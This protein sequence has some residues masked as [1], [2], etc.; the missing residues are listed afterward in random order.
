MNDLYSRYSVPATVSE[1]LT[2][3]VRRY[4]SAIEITEIMK[5]L[6]VII[7]WFDDETKLDPKFYLPS[8]ISGIWLLPLAHRCLELIPSDSDEIEQSELMI[9]EAL[10]HATILFMQ[11]IRRRFGVNPGPTDLRVRKLRAI[12]QQSLDRWHGFEALFR[13]I[14]V[15]ARM[16][17]RMIEDQLWFAGVLA[18]YEPF[19]QLEEEEHL[20]ALRAFIWKEDVFEEP[21]A[22]FMDQVNEIKIS[23]PIWP[24][25]KSIFHLCARAREDRAHMLGSYDTPFSFQWERHFSGNP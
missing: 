4:P 9:L 17:A 12:L 20:N 24:P 5:D 18:M 7:Q 1:Q 16:E 23:S 8:N 2:R 22:D 14:V 6:S 10:R 13:W 21:F 11:P 19:Q 3:L 25:P 15:A